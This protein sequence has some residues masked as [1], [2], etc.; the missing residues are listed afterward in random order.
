M[1]IT[2]RALSTLLACTLAPAMDPVLAQGTA[3][4]TAPDEGGQLQEVVVSAQKREERLQDTPI[5]ISV[6]SGEG[7]E[8]H[9]VSSLGDIGQ[10]VPNVDISS[11][12]NAGGGSS[13][14]QIY[15]RGIGQND[16]LITTD[17]GVGIYIDGVYFGR[18][19]GGIMDLL[20]LERV[21]ILRG[22]QG[23]LFG[24]NTIGGALNLI[25]QKPSRE[26]G[27]NVQVGAGNLSR[28]EVRGSIDMPLS[29]QWLSKL[30]VSHKD[31]DGYVER[32]FGGEDMGDE[33]S[34]SARLSLQWNPSDA[35][36]ANFVADGTRV[37]Q[38]SAPN[39]V[40]AFRDAGNLFP[41]WAGVASP[42]VNCPTGSGGQA[43]QDFVAGLGGL[44]YVLGGADPTRSY[45][46][47]PNVNDLDLWGMAATFDYKA[48]DALTFKSITAYRTFDAQFGRDGDGSPYQYI[49]TDDTVNQKQWSQ[50][51]QLIGTSG[52]LRWVAGLYYYDE[53]AT[54]ANDVKLASGLFAG[55]EALPAAVVPLAPVTCP[56]PPGEFAPC[57]GGA[58]NPINVGLD[59]DFNIF[60]EVNTRSYAGFLQGTYELTARLS[61]TVGLRYTK[62]DKEYFLDHRRANS[63]AP[64]IVPTTVGNDFNAFTPKAALDYKF[65]DDLLGYVS[66]SRGFKSGGFNGRPTT[67]GAVESFDPEYLTTYEIGMK[68]EWLDQRVRL[69]VAAF[70]NDYTDVQLSS[71]RADTT[72]NLVLVVENAG[73]GESKGLEVE[74]QARPVRALTLD[75]AI[76]LIDAEYTE[77]D[78][79]ATVTLDTQFMK[80][81]EVT[82]SAGAAYTWSLA[83]GSSLTFRGDWNYRDEVWNDVANT[84]ELRQGSYGLL[85]AR[86]TYAAPD[87]K[88]ELTA[89]G[90]NLTDEEYIVSG[91][92]AADSFGEIEATLGR[93]REYGLAATYRF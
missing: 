19:T 17:P 60:N 47:G 48:S 10:Y 65:T 14:A 51:F 55:L 61:G 44:P 52:R 29:D 79:G 15:I 11:D 69:N 36:E 64:I 71:A 16:F 32:F 63:G 87:D 4:P 70:F 50:E 12:A 23:T 27:G 91:I 66:V 72:G 89:W 31:R 92:S 57:A 3:V 25:S 81:P 30:S 37:R 1:K 5:A 18:A 67:Q 34:T 45:A 46:T 73:K 75:A 74:L 83:A 24:K 28:K 53:E 8:D 58:G 78:P 88:W 43:C 6:F 39:F 20:D 62:E 7:L 38:N 82:A 76:G 26:F 56:P 49:A 13:N 85:G 41:L 93:P 40:T 68:S 21:E 59:L 77:L 86:L 33:N 9:N 22:P 80:T 2:S 84:P 54:D 42:V 90:T 35:L